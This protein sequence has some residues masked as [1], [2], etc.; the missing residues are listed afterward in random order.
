MSSSFGASSQDPRATFSI[1]AICNPQNMA[2]LE[3]CGQEELAR[4]LKDGV[5]ADELAK[6]RQGYLEALKV[7]RSGDTAILGSLANYR[8]LG[9]TMAWQTD[10]ENKVNALTPGP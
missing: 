9:R 7:A 10:Y 1:N 3:V 5:T 6:A 2:R 8:H 4:L